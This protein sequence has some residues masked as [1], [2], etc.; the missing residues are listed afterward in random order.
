[1]QKIHKFEYVSERRLNIY[2]KLVNAW[3]VSVSDLFTLLSPH[4]NITMRFDDINVH[5]FLTY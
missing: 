2:I 5:I 4:F 3:F 1:M